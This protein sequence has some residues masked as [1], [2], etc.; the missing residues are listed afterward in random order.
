MRSVRSSL[1]VCTAPIYINASSIVFSAILII[2]ALEGDLYQKFT[3]WKDL[4]LVSWLCI[5]LM[6]CL[7]GL[8]DVTKFC[9]Y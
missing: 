4:D 6:G 8:G 1:K 9:A 3:F 7:N 2:F 5:C